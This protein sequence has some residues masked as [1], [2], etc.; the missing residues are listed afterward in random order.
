MV[1]SS[2]DVSGVGGSVDAAVKALEEKLGVPIDH[3]PQVP[4]PKP[5]VIIISGPSGVGKDAVIK[6]LQERRPELH[7]VVTA[8]SR[9]ARA[10]EVHGKDYF[11]ISK[12]EFQGMID[13]GELLEHAVVYGEFKGIP[14]QQ[15]RETMDRGTDVVLRIDVQGAATVRSMLGDG[16]VF[17]FLAAESEAA[18]V[19]RLVERKTESLEKVLL[20]LETAR[21][22]SKRMADF[23]YVVVNADGQLDRTVDMI[24]AII[25]VEKARVH[26]REPKL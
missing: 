12:E 26:P 4:P 3:G 25:D 18:L 15:V 20:R 11:F 16:G 24:A 22:E 13:G 6:R 2:E 14:K 8:T 9:K 10:G 17:I 5:L 21:E 7:M 1:V 19:R 23:D